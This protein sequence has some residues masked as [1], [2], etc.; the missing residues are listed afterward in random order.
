MKERRRSRESN[1]ERHCSLSTRETILLALPG[2]VY[3]HCASLPLSLDAGLWSI[4]HRVHPVLSVSLSA[5]L[6]PSFSL[7]VQWLAWRQNRE[8]EKELAEPTVVESDRRSRLRTR[9]R[10]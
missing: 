5:S 8:R 9:G 4:L 1:R 10:I 6:C 2:E 7:R 3:I